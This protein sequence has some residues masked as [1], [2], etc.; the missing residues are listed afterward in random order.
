[1]GSAA[2]RI[3]RSRSQMDLNERAVEEVPVRS[4]YLQRAK[5]DP[6]LIGQ[7]AEMRKLYVE[8]LRTVIP[9]PLPRAET[10]G[11]DHQM[12]RIIQWNLN[13]LCGVDGQSAQTATEI[14]KIVERSTADILLFQEAPTGPAQTWWWEPWRSTFPVREMRRLETSLK[15]MGYTTQL[16]TECFSQTLLCT[17]LHVREFQHVQ[18]DLQHAYRFRMEEERAAVRAVL[19][20][21]AKD[22]T[23]DDNVISVY[24][25]HFH[26][27]NFTLGAE[28]KQGV[29]QAEAKVL[30]QHVAEASVGPVLVATD[31]NQARRQDY[32]PEEWA[33]IAKGVF[34]MGE[35]EDDG[36]A[37]L[38]EEAGFRCAYDM[39]KK[40]NWPVSKAPPFT[41]WTGTTVDY[42]YV[43]SSAK[44][45]VG[46]DG[47]YIVNSSVSDHL[48][49]VTD[50]TFTPITQL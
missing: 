44:R 34:S 24:A 10:S 11:D 45:R 50:I 20:F 18:L 5:E 23:S 32:D 43:R 41:H 17:N 42:P 1:M 27:Q 35:P 49:I 26:H 37:E 14:L 48:P 2:G 7:A 13:C 28:S 29:R 25:T 33:V 36:V 3:Y 19:H 8:Q 21:G 31:F 15:R 22:D 6:K 39:A 38:F 40:R 9:S 47:V 16:R 46:V 12:L 4:L 30:L